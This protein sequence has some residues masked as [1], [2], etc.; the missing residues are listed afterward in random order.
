MC[1]AV[2]LAGTPI[3]AAEATAAASANV[4][5]ELKDTDVKSAIEAL[6]RNTGKNYAIDANVQGTR[7]R[8]CPSRMCRSTRP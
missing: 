5:L 2:H 8:R 4:N 3:V 6:F 7:S 1:G